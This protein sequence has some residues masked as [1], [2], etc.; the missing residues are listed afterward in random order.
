VT[1]RQAILAVL[2]GCLGKLAHADETQ[3]KFVLGHPLP[4]TWTAFLP[5]DAIVLRYGGDEVRLS[6]AEIMAALKGAA[7]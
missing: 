4:T 2:A 7:P 1:K 3:P 5:P 6:S